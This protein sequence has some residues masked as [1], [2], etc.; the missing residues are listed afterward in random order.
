MTATSNIDRSTGNVELTSDFDLNGTLNIRGDGTITLSG[1]L[2]GSG[3]ITK[4][5]NRTLRLEGTDNDFDSDVQVNDG[6]VI[7]TDD[8]KLKS[9][10]VYGFS[11]EMYGNA[12]YGFPE[13]CLKVVNT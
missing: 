9:D 7:V 8:T 6:Q 10:G 12:G 5:N 2:G 3:S 4:H 1:S 13:L 11:A